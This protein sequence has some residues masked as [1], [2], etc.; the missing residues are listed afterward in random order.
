MLKKRARHGNPGKNLA[1]CFTGQQTRRVRNPL[2]RVSNQSKEP[3]GKCLRRDHAKNHLLLK[4]RASKG[5]SEKGLAIGGVGEGESS[6][7]YQPPNQDTLEQEKAGAGRW[8]GEFYQSKQHI[9]R[10]VKKVA[11]SW[12][13]GGESNT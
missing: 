2:G 12:G 7:N 5:V 13:H 10:V 4:K 1:V 8:G 11:F 6:E 3:L 9:R